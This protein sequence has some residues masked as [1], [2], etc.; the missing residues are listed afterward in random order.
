[1]ARYVY[2]DGTSSIGSI[3]VVLYYVLQFVD[4][5]H[6]HPGGQHRLRRLP[7]RVVDHRQRRLPAAPAEQPGRPARLLERHPGADPSWPAC[8]SSASAAITSALIPLYAVGVFTGFTLSQAGMVIHHRQR[9]GEGLAPQPGDQRRR[10]GGHRSSCC[11]SWS[12][13]SSPIGAWIPVA[14]IPID[15]GVLPVDP[16]ALRP[17]RA[18][19]PSARRLPVAAATATPSSCWSARC[20]A[21]C[22]TPSPTPGPWRPIASSPCPSST[23]T[24]SRSASRRSVGAASTSPSSSARCTRPTASCPRRCSVHRRPRQGVARRHRHRRR[25]RVRA[26]PLVGAVAAQPERP[27]AASTATDATEHRVVTVP[28]PIHVLPTA[29][30]E[31]RT[32]LVRIRQG[33]VLGESRRGLRIPRSCRPS[34]RTG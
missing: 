14:L 9:A 25:S 29:T 22:S 2:T 1:M 17:G 7:A 23:T 11:S 21:A 20:T 27:R 6:P 12:S 10:R 19:H 30:E 15:R 4:L 33:A 28:V 24:S 13:R 8:S 3:G 18:G 16:A 31:R 32:Q 26:Q 5:R 34:P